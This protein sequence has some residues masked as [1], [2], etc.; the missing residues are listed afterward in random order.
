MSALSRER[1]KQFGAEGKRRGELL[2]R[3]RSKMA[4]AS[5]SVVRS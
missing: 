2:A 1:R 3:R 5:P 4:T